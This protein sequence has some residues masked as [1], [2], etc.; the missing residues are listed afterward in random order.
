MMRRTI[1]ILM[2]TIIYNN[3]TYATLY[4]FFV[5]QKLHPIFVRMPGFFYFYFNKTIC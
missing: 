4:V 1:F 2:E 5:E 3:M